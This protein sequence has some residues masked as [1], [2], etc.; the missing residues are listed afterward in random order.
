VVGVFVGDEDSIDTGG[1]FA[2]GCEAEEG[3]FLTES[4][5]DEDAGLLRP[6]KDGVARTRTGQNTNLENVAASLFPF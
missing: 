4:G 3:L 1:V 2:Y 6:D 5:V